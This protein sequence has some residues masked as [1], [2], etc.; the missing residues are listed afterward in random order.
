MRLVRRYLFYPL[1]KMYAWFDAWRHD[2]NKPFPSMPCQICGRTGHV[3]RLC[4]NKQEMDFWI[5][6]TKKLRLTGVMVPSKSRAFCIPA[7]RLKSQL[8]CGGNNTTT[9]GHVV[10]LVENSL[11]Q[12]LS[13][14][15]FL[16]LRKLV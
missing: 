9:L 14:F 3:A 4:P 15:N 16:K 10:L 11:F 13:W 2:P 12:P 7:D 1:Y 6:D 8:K 5:G